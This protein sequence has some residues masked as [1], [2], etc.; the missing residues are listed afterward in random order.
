MKGGSVA[1]AIA[2]V[3]GASGN[4]L[5]S[6]LLVRGDGTKHKLMGG[7]RSDEAITHIPFIPLAKSG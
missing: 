7:C 4:A 5:L 1:Q 2:G 6:L 3:E